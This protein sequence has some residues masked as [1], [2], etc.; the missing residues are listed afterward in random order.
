MGTVVP[1]RLQGPTQFRHSG[2][3]TSSVDDKKTLD[4]ADAVAYRAGAPRGPDPCA[5]QESD[6]NRQRTKDGG[7]YEFF[8]DAAQSTYFAAYC[9]NGYQSSDEG[10]SNN[11]VPSGEDV[12]PRPVR[13]WPNTPVSRGGMSE[14]DAAFVSIKGVLDAATWTFRDLQRTAPDV[15]NTAKMLSGADAETVVALTTRPP[16]PQPPNVRIPS[17]AARQVIATVLNDATHHLVYFRKATPE[18]FPAATAK[19]PGADQRTIAR[20]TERP[21]ANVAAH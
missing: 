21:R 8:I 6:L 10:T 14:T 19:F 7:K 18:G 2:V 17:G 12:R 4:G 3:V 16:V 5:Q 20:L 13:L 11:N 9:S 1:P 15:M